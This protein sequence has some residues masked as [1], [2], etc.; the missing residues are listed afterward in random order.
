[1]QYIFPPLARIALLRL[2]YSIGTTVFAGLSRLPCFVPAV[3]DDILDA[4]DTTFEAVNS[5]VIVAIMAHNVPYLYNRLAK[6]SHCYSGKM[7]QSV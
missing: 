7:N 2:Q 4:A 3:I 6:R 5:G 1:M